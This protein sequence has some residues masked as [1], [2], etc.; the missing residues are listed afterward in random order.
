MRS[1]SR[2]Y[3]RYKKVAVRINFEPI[4]RYHS[5]ITQPCDQGFGGAEDATLHHGV[6]ALGQFHWG[7]RQVLKTWRF[8]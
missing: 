4:P 5:I 3:H 1:T 2:Y 8:G 7:Y 6:L